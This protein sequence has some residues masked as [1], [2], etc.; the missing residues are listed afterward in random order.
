[1]QHEPCR[2]SNPRWTAVAQLREGEAS[3]AVGDAAR[4]SDAVRA[5]HGVAS[6]SGATPLIADVEAVARRTRIGLESPNEVDL[7]ANVSQLGLTSR[8][9]EVL[10]LVA[11]GRTNRQIGDQRYVSQKTASVHVSNILR[12][13]GVTSRVDAAAIAQRSRNADRDRPPT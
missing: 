12:K 2:G 6:S 3:M 9:V 13:L 10:E 11:A 8:E 1:M 5:A 7:G 4:A